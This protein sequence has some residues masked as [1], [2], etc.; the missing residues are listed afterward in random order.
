MAGYDTNKGPQISSSVG[1]LIAGTLGRHLGTIAEVTVNS[2]APRAP[3]LCLYLLSDLSLGF[4]CCCTLIAHLLHKLP[5][6]GNMT[7]RAAFDPRFIAARGCFQICEE[8]L[9]REPLATLRHDALD[10]LPDAEKLAA[11]LK[12]QVFVQKTAVEARAGLI[13]VAENHHRQRAIFRSRRRDTHGV[14]ESFHVVV[15]EEPIACLAQFS[16]APQIVQL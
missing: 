6:G 1:G 8:L 15:L 11:G 12:E 3:E 10:E 14:I 2:G 13:P 16:F 9:I 7:G 4:R 5:H